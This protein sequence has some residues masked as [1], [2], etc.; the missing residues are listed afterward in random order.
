MSG[1]VRPPDPAGDPVCGVGLPVRLAHALD[2]LGVVLPPRKAPTRLSGPLWV[3]DAS[4]P[5]GMEPPF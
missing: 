4:V 3:P 5:G 2:A 1:D